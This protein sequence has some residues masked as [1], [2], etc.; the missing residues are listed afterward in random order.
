MLVRRQQLSAVPRGPEAA[1]A[2][3]TG[4]ARVFGSS[5]LRNRVRTGP[6]PGM[7]FTGANA[8]PG[9]QYPICMLVGKRRTWNI[10]T[11]PFKAM[12]PPEEEPFLFWIFA[13]P[14]DGPPPHHA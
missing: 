12:P 4:H 6:L 5:P 7:L 13:G 8:D 10:C 11:V 9:C 2:W 14:R 3:G 1:M